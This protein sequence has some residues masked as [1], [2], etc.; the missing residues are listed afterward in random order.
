M[1]NSCTFFA[2]RERR[3]VTRVRHRYGRQNAIP[4]T[5]RRLFGSVPLT[6][7]SGHLNAMPFCFHCITQYLFCNQL[8]VPSDCHALFLHV[9]RH[10]SE[11]LRRHAGLCNGFSNR[12]IL[13]HPL[14]GG[15][16]I[17]RTEFPN[18][19]FFSKLNEKRCSN[20]ALCKTALSAEPTRYI[21]VLVCKL[22]G[23]R[24]SD[25]GV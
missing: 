8:Y 14:C 10:A 17:I 1:E 3:P 11:G 25:L 12:P 16:R 24:S 2:G 20:E 9:S 19:S 21:P 6:M 4:F 22:N 7:F 15:D 13:I 18:L 5:R 23:N